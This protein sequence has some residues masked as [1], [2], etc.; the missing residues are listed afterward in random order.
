M[1]L[2]AGQKQE[3][4]NSKT[5]AAFNTKPWPL[6]IAYEIDPSLS[7]YFENISFAKYP[8]A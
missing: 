7:E 8:D 5:F 1:I 4:E 6:P 3:I 2:T